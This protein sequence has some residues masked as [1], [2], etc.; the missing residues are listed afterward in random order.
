MA[1]EGR[2]TIPIM[3]I[4]PSLRKAFLESYGDQGQVAVSP[5][6]PLLEVAT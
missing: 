3:S 5:D 4:D 6:R 2:V 1:G